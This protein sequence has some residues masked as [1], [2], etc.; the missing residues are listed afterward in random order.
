MQYEIIFCIQ[1][2]DDT[3][4]EVVQKLI[5][6]HPEVDASI[7]RGTCTMLWFP[8]PVTLDV[9]MCVSR[10]TELGGIVYEVVE[11]CLYISIEPTEYLFKSSDKNK[12]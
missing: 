4:I 6:S 11:R 12:L 7:F 3:L 9:C 5:A 10:Q 1:S 8:C 2:E